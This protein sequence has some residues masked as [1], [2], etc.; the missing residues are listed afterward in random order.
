[1]DIQALREK[2]QSLLYLAG[3][4]SAD[5]LAEAR[6]MAPG[7]EI[8]AGLTPESARAYAPRAHAVE[9]Q[10]L[11]AEFLAEA[12][13]LVWVAALSAGV[14]QTLEWPGLAER[15]SLPVELEG[16]NTEQVEPAPQSGA[17]AKTQ[18]LDPSHGAAANPGGLVLTSAK[19][20]HGP[21]IAE[22]VF[23]LLLAHVRGLE[24]HR[25]A[26]T[27]GEWQ[28]DGAGLSSLAGQTLLVAGLGGIGEQV[29]ERAKAFGMRV[30]ATVRTPRETPPYVDQLVTAERLDELL[31]A[32]QFVVLCL[33]LTPETEGL[34]DARRLA[35]LP[36]GAYLV[37]IARGALVDTD[38]LV[39]AIQSGHLAGAGLD[40]T[41]PEPPPPGHPLWTLP[42]V[43]LTPHVAGRAEL[44]SQRRRALQ[45]E[46]LRRFSVGEPLL[47]VVDPR[48]GY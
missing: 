15:A 23:A 14:E 10:L 29:A 25:L 45:L 13:H 32:A 46:N 8:V 16:Q 42:G 34:F 22:H 19:G 48:A 11:S 31:P 41:E 47:N 3:N 30:L 21:V 18:P 44:T 6:K 12:H 40:V 5:Q 33:P 4:W 17:A 37:N 38:A 35:L 2:D 1:M 36:R 26:Q 27:R 9:A 7:V 39:A 20:V 43:T 24:R 28:R